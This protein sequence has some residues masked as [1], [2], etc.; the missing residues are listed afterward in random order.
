MT[1]NRHTHSLLL[2]KTRPEGTGWKLYLM[3]SSEAGPR[4]MPDCGLIPQG[5][6][7]CTW[8]PGGGRLP[9][10]GPLPEEPQ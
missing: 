5:A 1:V 10:E 2:V 3:A 4:T 6:E 8:T 7:C 9:R